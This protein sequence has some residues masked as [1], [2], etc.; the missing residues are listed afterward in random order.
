[1]SDGL[2]SCDEE[3]RQRASAAIRVV[4]WA[5][6]NK[7]G[8]SLSETEEK[9]K[10]QEPSA[11]ATTETFHFNHSSQVLSTCLLE[12]TT[13]ST[14]RNLQWYTTRCL[15][16]QQCEEEDEDD[17]DDD[18]D[19]QDTRNKKAVA[20]VDASLSV[21]C[22]DASGLSHPKEEDH[23]ATFLKMRLGEVL[24]QNNN[25]K[26]LH[27]KQE[28][29]STLPPFE[30]D[31]ISVEILLTAPAYIPMMEKRYTV[32]DLMLTDNDN[33]TSEVEQFHDM[34]VAVCLQA[35]QDEHLSNIYKNVMDCIHEVED[36]FATHHPNIDYGR[37]PF[38]FLEIASRGGERYDALLDLDEERW[39]TLRK[40]AHDDAPWR[41]FIDAL[42]PSTG[43]KVTASIVYSR[44]GATDQDWHCDGRHY[45]AETELD[46]HGH[47]PPYGVC[48]FVPLID[49]DRTV[50][51][52]QFF[53]KSHKTS[54]LV[55][56]GQ[57]SHLLA[58]DLDG[59]LRAGQ[60]VIYDYRNMHRGMANESHNIVRPVVQFLYSIPTFED[61][62][63]YGTLSMY[64]S[65]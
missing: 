14:A 48:V 20:G 47:A 53:L 12:N 56:F 50:G 29:S 45:D 19:F 37:D 34:G 33:L 23:L 57:A 10:Q 43:W 63:N 32:Q 7:E 38:S 42:F 44:P 55:G 46:G 65:G 15:T 11:E 59:I 26:A 61:T 1:M 60:S 64:P 8:W 27:Q 17:N 22:Q 39:K 41:S 5:S 30:F 18:E 4:C 31:E 24:L 9:Q 21:I 51:F 13:W 2:R 49:L 40:V 58:A 36:C 6:S 62:P 52:T 54:Q 16:V 25:N 3:D 28:Q 35:I